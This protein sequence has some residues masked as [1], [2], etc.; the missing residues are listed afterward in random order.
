MNEYRQA[1]DERAGLDREPNEPRGPLSMPLK[2][3][4][5]IKM[6]EADGWYLVATRGS[7]RQYKHP[8]KPGRVTV[9]G[10]PSKELPPGTERSILRQARTTRRAQ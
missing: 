1:L 8:V 9:A 4:E 7:H 2:V 10:K 3:S 5:I 6:I